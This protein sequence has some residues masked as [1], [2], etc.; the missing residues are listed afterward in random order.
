M[1]KETKKKPGATSE[2]DNK[3]VENQIIPPPAET[4]TA[5]NN[6][7]E[8]SNAPTE[9]TSETN[10]SETNASE[11]NASETN[12]VGANQTDS[13]TVDKSVPEED[14]EDEGETVKSGFEKVSIRAICDDGKPFC[15]SYGSLH[16]DANGESVVT[17]GD[18]DSLEK[19]RNQFATLDIKQT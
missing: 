12:T 15:G 1:K 4:V 13:E 2:S 14:E 16:F 3:P 5:E 18:R 6:Q 11:E 7:N 19:L 8:E 17:I 10:A 9:N